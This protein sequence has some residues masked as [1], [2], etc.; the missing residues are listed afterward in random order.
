MITLWWLIA[1]RD[2]FTI[3]LSFS[4]VFC[5]IFVRIPITPAL[6][7]PSTME[8]QTPGGAAAVS[9]TLLINTSSVSVWRL[10]SHHLVK[11]NTTMTYSKNISLLFQ[12]FMGESLEL[13]SDF[14]NLS[15]CI[16][17]GMSPWVGEADQGVDWAF[18]LQ[19]SALYCR[20]ELTLPPGSFAP[21][22]LQMNHWISSSELELYAWLRMRCL[23]QPALWLIIS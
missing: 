7:A 20:Q 18:N 19:R 11:N 2:T 8:Q 9:I 22:P 6:N 12:P 14:F 21:H 23:R 4:V 17:F 3:V 15:G 13:W 16:F 1:T 10:F 5:Y